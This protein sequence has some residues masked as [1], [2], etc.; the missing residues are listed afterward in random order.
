[1]RVN[2]LCFNP[3]QPPILLCGSEDHNLYTFDMRN[4]SS[5]TQ[6]YKGHVGA[7]VSY[8]ILGV[9]FSLAD[10]VGIPAVSCLVIGLLVEE[11]SL[12]EVMIER[13][14]CGRMEK[15][16]HEIPITQ[17]ECNGKLSSSRP[18]S[19]VSSTYNPPRRRVF[20]TLY[21]L[22][23]RFVLSGSD[24][25]NLRIWKSRAGDKLGVVDKKE[26]VQREYREELR[27]KW[28]TVAEVSKIERYVFPSLLEF[29]SNAD[30]D[31]E[32]DYRQ[33]YLPKPIH[34][35]TKLRREMLDAASNKED[36]RRRHAPKGVDPESLKPK[37]QR[38]VAIQKVEG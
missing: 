8:S 4:L 28:S 18:S 23:T 36:N 10:S 14:D 16:V 12:V 1:M 21:T 2:Q 33:R 30:H 19:Y 32:G 26:Q 7:Y 5:T 35:A 20:S 15:E 27:N 6:V 9:S 25:A 3:L 37:A 38:K 31:F 17:N 29:A 13:F 34:Q 11:S 24:D 22:D